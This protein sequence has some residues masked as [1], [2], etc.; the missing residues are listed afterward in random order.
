[1]VKSQYTNNMFIASYVLSAQDIILLYLSPCPLHD[2]PP[3]PIHKFPLCSSSSL[4]PGCSISGIFQLIS[5]AP[6][7]H[8]SKPTQSAACSFVS[9]PSG[10][11]SPL[12]SSFLILY[13]L[14]TPPQQR[15]SSSSTLSKLTCL[16]QSFDHCCGLR[17]STWLVLLPSYKPLLLN[18][19]HPGHFPHASKLQTF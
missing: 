11:L 4:P 13:I 6:P 8:M 19:C 10:L 15:I 9:K 5:T 18:C 14:V 3:H 17:H 1:M 12:M 2:L 16:V 7:L